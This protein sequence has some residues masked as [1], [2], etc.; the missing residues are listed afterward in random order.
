[1]LKS[2][3]ESQKKN[4]AWMNWLYSYYF[5][6]EDNYS[7]YDI[8]CEQ[9]EQD[10][11]K[12]KKAFELPKRNDSMRRIYAYLLK[13]RFLD[14]EVI[15]YFIQK[16]LIY[17]DAKYHNVVFVGLD[18]EGVARHAHKRGTNSKSGFKG[19][20]ESS[21]PNY[22][23]HHIGTSNRIYVFEA[24]IDMLSYISLHKDNWKEH[25]Y[26]SLCSVAPHALIHILQNNPN[27]TE[28]TLSQ[29]V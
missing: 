14:R 19:N 10:Q 28:V 13:E 1:M 21:N 15:Q 2:F 22:S 16:K 27:I 29:H 12:E 20:I 25:S 24:P 7:G 17:E 3:E 5:D 4:G 6:G 8:T 11:Q 9:V 23:F 26:V 18:E